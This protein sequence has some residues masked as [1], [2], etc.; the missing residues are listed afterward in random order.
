MALLERLLHG[1]PV[2]ITGCGTIGLCRVRKTFDSRDFAT[3][4]LGG[5]NRARLDREAIEVNGARTARRCVAADIRAG[6]TDIFSNVMHKQGARL[7]VV[8]LTL[9]IDVH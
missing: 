2:L 1:V 5:E 8:G 3:H 9:S 4:C 7:N 6:Q